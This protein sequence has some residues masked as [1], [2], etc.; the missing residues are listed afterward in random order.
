MGCCSPENREAV[1]EHEK[2]VNEK[3]K[4]SLHWPIK[5]GLVL[6]LLGGITAILISY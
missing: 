1:V 3:G 2:R 6:I 5:A 4:D